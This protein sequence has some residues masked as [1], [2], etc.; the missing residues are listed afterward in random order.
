MVLFPWC[1][2][3]RPPACLTR[4]SDA[5]RP[6]RCTPPGGPRANTERLEPIGLAPHLGD[7]PSDLKTCAAPDPAPA[8]TFHGKKENP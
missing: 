1:Q 7:R 2:R 3:P 5:S 8:F 4:R 6:N